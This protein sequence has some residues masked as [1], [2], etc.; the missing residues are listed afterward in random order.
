MSS[1]GIRT[2]FW[3][4]HAWGFLFS[5]IAGRYPIAFDKNNKDHIKIV[6]SFLAMFSN[7]QN[8]LPCCH[9]RESYKRFYKDL[10]ISNYTQSRRQMM[11]WLY[12]IHDKV[13]V[14]LIEQERETYENKKKEL[15]HQN[16]S[17]VKMKTELKK[18]KSEILK[19][20]SS[21]PFDKVVSMYEKQRG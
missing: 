12:L 20:K 9:C 21:P 3:G 6:K 13:N 8:L 14:K 5:S 11:K 1:N 17:P 2:S 10:P 18:L 15:S 7:M 16:L 19:T 4:P